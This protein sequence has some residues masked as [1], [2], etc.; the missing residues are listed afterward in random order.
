M[1]NLADEN[2]YLRDTALKAGKKIIQLFADTAI[3]LLLPELE[4]GL[5]HENWRIRYSSV[6]LLGDLLFHI[7]GVTG[8]QSSE[9]G[10]GEDNFGTSD[11]QKM[12]EKR[13]GNLCYS[14]VLAGIYMCRSDVALLVRQSALHVWKLTVYNTARTIREVLPVLIQIILANLASDYDEKRQIA[15]RTLGKIINLKTLS[16]YLRFRRFGKETWRT[17]PA[18]THANSQPGSR[19]RSRR[20][21]TGRVRR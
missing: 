3:A 4:Q 16:V 1:A 12:I 15:S 17:Y 2:E 7:T 6:Q 5:L 14:R 20:A 9:G 11:G 8:K 18:K 19:I 10:T 13:L 21:E